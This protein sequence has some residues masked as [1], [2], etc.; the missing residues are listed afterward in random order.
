MKEICWFR[1]EPVHFWGVGGVWAKSVQR[2]RKIMTKRGKHGSWWQTLKLPNCMLRRNVADHP[3]ELDPSRLP[4]PRRR[5][6]VKLSS[7]P[8]DTRDS[9][10]SKRGSSSMRSVF[11]RIGRMANSEQR[12]VLSQNS[13]RPKWQERWKR[14]CAAVQ[15]DAEHGNIPSRT[16]L[17][18]LNH[19]CLCTRRAGCGQQRGHC[20]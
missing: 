4:Y 17:D 15:E 1:S 10:M 5:L 16:A 13:S 3:I 18:V 20:R 6:G 19:A 8:A 11:S 12:G 7:T 9:S 2:N 14:S